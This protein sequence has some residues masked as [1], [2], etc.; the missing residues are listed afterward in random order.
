MPKNL[1][2]GSKHKKFKNSNTSEIT[3]KDMILKEENQDYAKVE[4]LLGNCRVELL[5]NDGEKRLGIIRGNMR[6]KQWI[7]SNSIVLYSVRDYEKDKV[8]IIHVYKDLVVKQMENKMKLTFSITSEEQNMDDIF[9]YVS[10]EEEQIQNN[11][12]MKNK[13]SDEEENDIFIDNIK[14]NTNDLN[15]LIDEL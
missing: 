11:I 10:D 5:C 4:K 8:D 2:G 3:A 15:E 6:K 14:N 12:I 9:M 7:N 1:K 13:E